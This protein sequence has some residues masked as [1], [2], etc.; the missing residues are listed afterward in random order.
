MGSQ[1]DAGKM[2]CVALSLGHTKIVLS[3]FFG[4]HMQGQNAVNARIESKSILALHCDKGQCRA[5]QHNATSSVMLST[6]PYPSY[7]PIL[8]A[9]SDGERGKKDG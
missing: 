3:Q 8:G 9:I 6:Q 7:Y 5:M 2:R 1:H 4:D